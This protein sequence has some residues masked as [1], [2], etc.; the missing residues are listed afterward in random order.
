MNNPERNL[1]SVI[2]PLFARLFAFHVIPETN[3]D[4]VAAIVV[5]GTPPLTTQGGKGRGFDATRRAGK[6]IPLL[7]SHG[8]G[9]QY[10]RPII[11]PRSAACFR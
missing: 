4:Q 8:G 2:T 11:E 10:I 6:G 3:F 9:A 1:M 7:L 5:P